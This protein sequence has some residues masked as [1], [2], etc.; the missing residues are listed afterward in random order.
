VVRSHW[1]E[2]ALAEERSD[3]SPRSLQGDSRAD[4][5]IVGGGYTGLW[6]ALRL[7]EADPAIDVAIVEA[8]VCG[9]G[10]SGR[11]GGMILSWWA[12]FATLEKLCGTDGAIFLA[13]ASEEAVREIGALCDAHAIRADYRYDGWLWVA[14]SPAQ[15]GAWTETMEAI[16]R[17]GLRP[18]RTADS[19]E[20]QSRCASPVHLTGIFEESAAT[21]QPAKLA[22]G[23]RRLAL[24]HGVRIYEHS[25][26]HDLVDGER[27]TV[28]TEA[29]AIRADKVV[30]AMNA[31]GV[32][33]P[34]LRKAMVVVSSDIIVTE[35]LP[36]RLREIGWTNGLGISDSRMLV[37]YY[38]TTTDGRIAF[39][40]GGGGGTLGFG[41]SVGEAFEGESRYADYLR[42]WFEFTFPSLRGV[43][44]PRTW[45]GPIDRSKSAMPLFGALS[46][47]PNVLFAI[48]F[49]GNGI[50]PAAVAGRILASLA[51]ERKDEWSTC[52]LVRP[53]TRDFPPEPMRY[54]GGKLV[55]EAV[56]RRD[57]AED[58][59][60]KPGAIVRAVAA[61]APA[62]LSPVK[63]KS[64]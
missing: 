33:F 63:K 7:K 30:L 42:H 18:F 36:E 22:R 19:Q 45:T 39:G 28:R 55:Q 62:G 38:R 41:S 34:E 1:L 37:H 4:V 16:E 13:K 40:K 10:A 17:H 32:R 24:E 2:E 47:R 43:R 14:T 59:G 11:N 51:L 53:P 15:N 48:G 23:L 3:D 25:A 26:M 60:R 6:T 57:Q 12:K 49:S 44:C 29:G 64:S 58:E 56:R 27:P 8:D 5:C 21:V 35:P 52:G 46:G 54:F 61:L 9:G 50:G 31:W 20:I